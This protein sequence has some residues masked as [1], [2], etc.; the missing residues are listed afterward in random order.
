MAFMQITKK[1]RIPIPQKRKLVDMLAADKVRFTTRDKKEIVFS[2][3]CGQYKVEIGNTILYFDKF[4]E[5]FN[6]LKKYPIRKGIEQAAT[7]QTA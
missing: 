7:A 3:E 4:L 1:M 5:L 2:K 6:F